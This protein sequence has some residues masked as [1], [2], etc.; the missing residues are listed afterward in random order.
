MESQEVMKHVLVKLFHKYL[1]EVEGVVFQVEDEVGNP[2][3]LLSSR[4]QFVG[5]D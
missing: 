3:E 1:D 5:V 4:N 2:L